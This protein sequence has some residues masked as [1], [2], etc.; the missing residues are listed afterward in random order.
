MALD[1][2]QKE[3]NLSARHSEYE[4][5][6]KEFLGKLVGGPP[7]LTSEQMEAQKGEGPCL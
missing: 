1:Q 7:Y 6:L 2:L 5:G 4:S 3:K